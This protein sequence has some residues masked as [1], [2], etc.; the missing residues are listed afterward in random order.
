MPKTSS[1]VLFLSCLFCCFWKQTAAARSS[2]APWRAALCRA[3]NFFSHTDSCNRTL[4]ARG[5]PE[6]W[7]CSN[8]SRSHFNTSAASR[9]AGSTLN[10]SVDV[11]TQ[12][13]TCLLSSASQLPSLRPS[14]VTQAAV[15]LL[16]GQSDALTN[17]D[18][19]V[20]GVFLYLFMTFKNEVAAFLPLL[21]SPFPRKAR[22][23]LCLDQT[24]RQ[25]FGADG[26]M[27][28]VTSTRFVF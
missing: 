27:R 20:V 24:Q 9:A 5:R 11:F 3:P 17:K 12:R 10:V 4:Q 18:L 23:A 2:L 21:M 19:F 13:S 16:R 28:R 26:N 15:V 22:H 1:K 25:C 6:G 14:L 7:E 8:I